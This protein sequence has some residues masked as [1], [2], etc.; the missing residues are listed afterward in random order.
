MHTPFTLLSISLRE[1]PQ[2]ILSHHNFHK[3]IATTWINT[4]KEYRQDQYSTTSSKQKRKTSSSVSSLLARTLEWDST[5][6]N[7][8]FEV[9][10]LK[11]QRA[12]AITDKNIRGIPSKHFNPTFNHFPITTKS[13]IWCGLHKWVRMETERNM[14]YY[15]SCTRS[16][17]K[18][19]KKAKTQYSIQCIKFVAH[20]IRVGLNPDE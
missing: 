14:R 20:Y 4:E 1:Y 8:H 2:K 13:N 10:V 19:L 18:Y 17:F 6:M 15:P 7:S 16:R 11:K 12:T 9:K 5:K 3:A